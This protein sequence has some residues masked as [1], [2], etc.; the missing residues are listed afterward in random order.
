V[1]PK[2]LVDTSFV[3]AL[4]N[5]RDA[6]HSKASQLSKEFDGYPL[7]ITEGVLFEIGNALARSFKPQAIQIIEDFIRFP[8]SGNYTNNPT[9]L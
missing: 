1:S 9:P 5:K 2:I 8:E 4:V 6:H 3:I 7:V